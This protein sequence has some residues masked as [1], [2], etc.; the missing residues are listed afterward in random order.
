[1]WIKSNPN[2]GVSVKQEYLE[3]QAREARNVA[4]KHNQFVRYH[5]NT[6]T[7]S[8]KRE[9]SVEDWARGN[10][11]VEIES[12]A[13]CHAGM[14]LGRSS[15]FAAV[16]LCFPRSVEMDDGSTG[17]H[18]DII[19][20]SW[21]CSDGKFDVWREPFK[22]WITRGEISC[23]RG[24]AIDFHE[25]EDWIVEQSQ[26]YNIQTIAYDKTYA[27]EMALRLQDQ[28]GLTLFE[29][30]QAPRFY[31][32]PFRKFITE[33]QAGR[34]Y[35]GADPVLEWQAGNLQNSPKVS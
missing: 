26:R 7:E 15:D 10:H 23:T 8:R 5:A 32:E 35:H 11:A 3:A 31:N 30:T 17:V 1:M 9:I 34:I 29:F 6:Q 22:G 2:L 13:V 27:R 4:S 28:H 16:T 19:S 24:N 18:Y 20:R 12:G 21:T 25:V 14:D 33:L